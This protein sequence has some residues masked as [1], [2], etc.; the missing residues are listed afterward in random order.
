[1][2]YDQGIMDSMFTKFGKVGMVNASANWDEWNNI[3]QNMVNHEDQKIKIAMVGKY[4]TLADSYVSVKPCIK[5]CRC[6][7]RKNQ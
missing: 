6:T 5:T 2:L 1:M 4:V 7:D 3:A